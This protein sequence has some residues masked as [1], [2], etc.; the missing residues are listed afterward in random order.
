MWI[1]YSL[2]YLH[3][4]TESS[5]QMICLV[6]VCVCVHSFSLLME[7]LRYLWNLLKY[8][9][10]KRIRSE[11]EEETL[12]SVKSSTV[13]ENL[14]LELLLLTIQRNRFRGGL[15]VLQCGPLVDFL[16]SGQNPTTGQ[17]PDLLQRHVSYCWVRNI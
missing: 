17:N 8:E 7:E 15:D 12:F 16:Q 10:N 14:A 13:Q 2:F 4:H 5:S 11:Q 1:R 3:T 6:C 9:L